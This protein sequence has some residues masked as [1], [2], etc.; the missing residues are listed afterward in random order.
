MDDLAQAIAFLESLNLAHGD[1]RPDNILLDCDRIKV[2]DFDNT[3]EF[4]T[5]FWVL[6][7]P[8]GRELTEN[9][10]DYEI[11]GCTAGLLGPR[12]E[13]FA[14]GSIYYYINYGMEVYGDTIL[15]T[16]LRDRGPALSDLLRDMQFPVLVGDTMISKL[17]HQCWHNQFPTIASLAMSTKALLKKSF[18][19]EEHNPIKEG[20]NATL[21]TQRGS[22]GSNGP[23]SMGINNL[24]GMNTS[25]ELLCRELDQEGLF[26]FLRSIDLH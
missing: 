11:P 16:Q 2:T 6:Q 10:P 23:T 26:D 8:W 12:T 19:G 14:L 9:E 24:S 3:A 15:S 5:P 25:E 22:L 1:L 21:E 20:M 7:V 17:I 13:Q 18:G 4:G